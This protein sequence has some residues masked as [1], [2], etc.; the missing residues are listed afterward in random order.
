MNSKQ[1]VV[2]ALAVVSLASWLLSPR[3]KVVYTFLVETAPA[4]RVL[5]VNGRVRP[6][7][8]VDIRPAIGG[9]LVVLPFDVGDRVTAGQEVARIDDAPEAAAIAQAEA[10]VGAQEAALARVRRD[11]D[12]SETLGEFA[13]KRDVEQ[14]RFI[15]AESERELERRRASVVQ[16]RELRERR[17]LRA[18]FSGVILERP[19]DR[20]QTVG[21]ESVI[22]RLAD[23]SNP[24]ITVEVDEVYAT[25]I[26]AGTEALVSFP[27]QQRPIEAAVIYVE[28]RV[29]PATGARNVRV[30]LKGAPTI[31]APSGLTVTVNLIIERRDTAISVPRRAI[32]QSGSH[33]HVRIVSQGIVS[34]RQIEFIDWPSESVI[35]TEGL[36]PGERILTDPD[37]A[38]PGDRVKVRAADR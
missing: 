11:L 24:D 5:A 4:Q 19:V 22:Y 18:P 34:D 28:P 27:G 23:L 10:S 6:K 1:L 32:I 20:G 14:L 15:V 31:D 37:S 12:R 8:Q 26:R 17:V 30:S 9:E 36:K 25:E 38:K 2:A 21:L 7:M 33:M 16:A 13:T 3:E 35:V 29:D